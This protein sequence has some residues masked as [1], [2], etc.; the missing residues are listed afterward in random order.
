MTELA[1]SLVALTTA[2]LV[3]TGGEHRWD[4][5]GDIPADACV[6]VGTI[7]AL[8]P[9]VA[10]PFTLELALDAPDL[11]ATNRYTSRVTSDRSE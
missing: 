10:G 5:G 9:E 7:Q 2:R 11:K 4:W 8:A 6:R 1:V 3:W